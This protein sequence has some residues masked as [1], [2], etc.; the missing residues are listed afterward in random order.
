MFSNDK[1]N[2]GSAGVP[3]GLVVLRLPALHQRLRGPADVVLSEALVRLDGSP[4]GEL[5][6]VGI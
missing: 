2:N 6:H 1:M 5:I 4:S 3:A